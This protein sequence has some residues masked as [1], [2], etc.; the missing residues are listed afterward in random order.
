MNQENNLRITENLRKTIY[1]ACKNGDLE[2][3]NSFL[4]SDIVNSE[5][6]KTFDYRT[7]TP[8]QIYDDISSGVMANIAISNNQFEITK[9]IFNSTYKTD[10]LFTQFNIQDYFRAACDKKDFETFKFL[11]NHPKVITNKNNEIIGLLSRIVT[12]SDN[13]N[14]LE[15]LF[16]NF[17]SHKSSKLYQ[18]VEEGDIIIHAARNG[19]THIIKYILSKDYLKDAI[20]LHLYKDE[21]FRSAYRNGHLET[22]KYFIFDLKLELNDIIK[23]HIEN[24]KHACNEVLKMFETQELNNSLQLELDRPNKK[25]QKVKL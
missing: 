4:N 5:Y 3:I 17:P 18:N 1:E 7:L 6:Y 2:T 20:D 14:M 25:V 11:L 9:T 22:I 13:L 19:Y 12:T 15:Y 23:G 10:E 8:S 16:D 24:D 21:A